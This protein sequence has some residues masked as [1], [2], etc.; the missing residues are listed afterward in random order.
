[1]LAILASIALSFT[2]RKYGVPFPAFGVPLGTVIVSGRDASISP[3][4]VYIPV[5]SE[6]MNSTRVVKAFDCAT[7]V[8]K[9]V[10]GP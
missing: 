7:N 8:A 10:L 4:S 2:A 3:R 5:V 1:M 9:E 6:P